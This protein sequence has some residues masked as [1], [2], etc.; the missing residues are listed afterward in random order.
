MDKTLKRFIDA[1][2][3][4]YDTAYSEIENGKK[5]GHWMWYIFP[6][7]KGLGSSF[8]SIHY[9]IESLDEAKA[10]WNNDYLRNN[11]LTITEALLKNDDSAI[12]IFGYTDSMKLKSCMTLFEVATKEA[13]F[14]KVLDKFFDGKEDESTTKIVADCLEF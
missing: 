2:E 14:S 5:V 7:I 3:R 6:Q 9:A 12:E 1:Q 4:D 8:M 11:L 13:I 10:Y